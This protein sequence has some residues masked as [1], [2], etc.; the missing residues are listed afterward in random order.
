VGWLA[1]LISR[2][3]L[4]IF[5]TLRSTPPPEQDVEFSR[6]LGDD[7]NDRL[8]DRVRRAK[9]DRRKAGGDDGA[10]A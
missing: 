6:P 1:D 2:I 5:K 3:V 7:F 4:G 9:S 8:A 10:D